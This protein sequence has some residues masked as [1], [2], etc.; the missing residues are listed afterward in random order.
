MGGGSGATV[1][2][3]EDRKVDMDDGEQYSDQEGGI[4]IVDMADMETLDIMAPRGLPKEKEAVEKKK[5]LKKKV[6][7]KSESSD[8]EDNGEYWVVMSYDRK[9]DWTLSVA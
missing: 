7:K 4:E 5:K 8:E 2:L 6:V 9:K 1:R 3:P